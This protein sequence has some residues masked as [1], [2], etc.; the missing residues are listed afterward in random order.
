MKACKFLLWNRNPV[1]KNFKSTG[2]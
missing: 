1:I 2:F